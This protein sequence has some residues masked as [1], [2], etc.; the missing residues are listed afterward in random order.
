MIYAYNNMYH[1]YMLTLIYTIL[2]YVALGLLNKH[3][4]LSA[5]GKI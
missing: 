4:G 2:Y 5:M 1:F 3:Y